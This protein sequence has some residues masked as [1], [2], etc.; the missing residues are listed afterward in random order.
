MADRLLWALYVSLL[1]GGPLLL[2]LNLL[3]VI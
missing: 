2:A 3:E 1:I